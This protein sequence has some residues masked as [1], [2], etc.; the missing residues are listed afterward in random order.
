[1]GN[2]DEFDGT[3]VEGLDQS[4]IRPRDI[5][6]EMANPGFCKSFR[7]KI[8]IALHFVPPGTS[9]LFLHSIHATDCQY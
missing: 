2:R 7:D 4:C 6:E 1:M 5:P 3:S 9:F 8:G